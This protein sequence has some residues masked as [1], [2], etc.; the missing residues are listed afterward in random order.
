MANE[1]KRLAEL[2]K[3]R[4]L[5]RDDHIKHALQEQKIT[6][7]KIGEIL[8]SSGFVTQYDIA[9]SVAAQ[10]GMEYL[11]VNDVLPETDA[12]RLYNRNL[13]KTHT[14]L[15]IRRRDNTVDVITANEDLA[16][17][18]QIVSRHNS[19]TS[20]IFQGERNKINNAI[21][22][23]YFFLDN[24][25][26]ELLAREIAVV[27]AE[28]EAVSALD[29][30]L[31]NIFRLAI[32]NRATDIH[33]RPMEYTINVAFRI[34]GIMRPMFSLGTNMRRLTSTVKIRADLDISETRLPQDGRFSISV[35]NND[36]DIRV[37]TVVVPYGENVVMR[38]LSRNAGVLGIRQLGFMED[39]IKL[40]ELMFDQPQG[41]VLLAGPTGSGKTTTMYAGLQSLDVLTKN[42]MTVEDPIEYRMPMVRQTQTN[43]RAGYT[44]AE[45][46]KHFL[47]HDP[48][49]ILVGEIRDS[50]TAKT[51]VTAAET[52]HLVLS[53]LHTNN[54]LGV[55]PRLQSLGVLPYMIADSLV[56]VISQRLVRRICPNCKEEYAPTD[57]ERRYFNAYDL[58]KAYRGKGCDTCNGTGFYGRSPVYEI[59]RVTPELSAA[60]AREDDMD[61]LAAVANRKGYKNIMTISFEQVSRGVTSPAEVIR[62]LGSDE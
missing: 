27:G 7:R 59:L 11:D 38:I 1:R 36:Y 6:H 5:I 53:T 57:R 58:N 41:M 43:V 28:T 23:F 62:T 50:E 49:A 12:L 34:D 52:G 47:R 4:N 55:I 33:I 44:F 31:T 39:D 22:H 10:L 26:E 15:P 8:E 37:S 16:S 13:C 48:D 20:R 14:F 25:I 54:V 9:T 3:D 46:I 32:K 61:V 42:V 40:L 45:A 19:L 21:D 24:P 60:I 51:A 29:S 2:L 56:G 35:L 18:A 17:L 30:L